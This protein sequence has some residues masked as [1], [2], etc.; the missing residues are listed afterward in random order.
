MDSANNLTLAK[1][2]E[3]ISTYYAYCKHRFPGPFSAVRVVAINPEDKTATFEL[4][5]TPSMMNGMGSMHGGAIATLIDDCSSF[6]FVAI[7]GTDWS[8]STDL[9]ISYVS[10]C[11]E[12]DTLVIVGKS[13]NVGRKLM[14]GEVSIFLKNDDGTTGRLIAFGKHTKYILKKP[15]KL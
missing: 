13:S 4:Q 1:S 12:G 14:F 7:T 5:V 11:K 15:S 6:T 3:Y 10:A 8:V 2:Q 9:S